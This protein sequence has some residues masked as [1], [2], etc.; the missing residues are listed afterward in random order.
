MRGRSLVCCLA[1]GAYWEESLGHPSTNMRP[2]TR[3]ACVSGCNRKYR[4][5]AQ[6]AARPQVC[7]SRILQLARSPAACPQRDPPR[8]VCH[9]LRRCALQ[10]QQQEATA[11]SR[12]VPQHAEAQRSEPQPEYV[13]DAELKADGM[14]MLAAAA[15]PMLMDVQPAAAGNPLL[16][17]K[18][19]GGISSHYPALSNHS[20]T[21]DSS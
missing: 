12:S 8:V 1:V 19:V 21:A 9:S 17:G 11:P 7:G 5:H 10:T 15:M 6:L 16:T 20:L 4:N 2:S 18:T 13:T 3:R 14:L